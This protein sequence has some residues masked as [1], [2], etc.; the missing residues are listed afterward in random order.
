[1]RD[2]LGD[3][4]RTPY[5]RSTLNLHLQQLREVVNRLL[6]KYHE[7]PPE[8]ARS[9]SIEVWSA[10]KFLA[11]S[12]SKEIPYEVA[13]SLEQALQD[14]LPNPEQ[15]YAVTTALLDEQ[16]YYFRGIYDQFYDMV[17]AF[18]DVTFEVKLIQ[19]ALPRLYRHRPLYGV[20]LYHELGHFIDTYFKVTEFSLLIAPPALP[21]I[22]PTQAYE[23]ERSWR[24]EYF[25][26]LFAAGYTGSA[27]GVFLGHIAPNAPPSLSH[28]ATNDRLNNIAAFLAGNKTQII[29]L[30]DNALQLLGLPT[31]TIR[32][33]K[34]DIR[35][36][37][38]NIRPYP[39]ANEPELHGLIEA[40]WEYL[41]AAHKDGD[42]PWT[43]LGEEKTDRIINDV[44]EK[45]I[46]N[47]M[48]KTRWVDG[49]ANQ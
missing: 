48:I 37:L 11:G 34:P 36:F 26:D 6:N 45:S 49:T 25:A 23:V 32:Y 1:M 42:S 29:G 8:V 21:Q 41:S 17:S 7:I 10:S 24:K 43:E 20:A 5:F 19:I 38:N 30:F 18:L 9:I 28:P 2:Q 4:A 15:P 27:I 14:W 33:S 31:L 12:V 39:I 40:G 47:W 44:I 16:Q 22:N 46:R 13:F 3:L 35:P